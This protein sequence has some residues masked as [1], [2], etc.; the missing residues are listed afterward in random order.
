VLSAFS[1]HAQNDVYG[2][3]MQGMRAIIDATRR[4]GV[5]RLLVV[6][7]AGSLEAAPGL[8]VIDTPE[9]P[10]Q[11]KGTAQGALDALNLLKQESALNWTMLSPPAMIAPGERT[12][13]FRLGADQL[14]VNEQGES[15]ISVEDYAVAMIDELEKP[16][17]AR[18]RFTVG[19]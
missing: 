15:A 18:P 9:F 12:G 17:H 14:L 7:G 2:Y 10:A 16:A 5:A 8:L 6:G 1:G 19:Y 11:W 4:A 13:K 3:Y